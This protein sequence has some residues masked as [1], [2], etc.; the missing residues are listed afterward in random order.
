MVET[1]FSLELRKNWHICFGSSALLE[2]QTQKSGLHIICGF[3]IQHASDAGPRQPANSHLSQEQM[4]RD[5]MM[6]V[7]LEA[8]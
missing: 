8:F 4:I 2:S 7:L 1:R 6:S 5:G 3:K